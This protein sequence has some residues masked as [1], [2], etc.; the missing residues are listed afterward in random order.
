MRVI[1]GCE[2]S[3]AVRRA[4]RAL[5]HDAWS[6]DILPADDG[7]EH[8]YQCDIRDVPTGY[9]NHWDVGIFHPPC[10]RLT[11]SGVR[12]LHERNLWG[13][14][15]EAAELFR[16]CLAFPAKRKAVENP[17]PHRYALERI[18][19]KYD[20][21]IQPWQFGHGETKA[22][23]LWLDGLPPLEPTDVVDGR[24]AR[25]HRMSPSADRWKMRS[26]TYSGIAQAMAQQWGRGA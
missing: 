23:C 12:W 22:T 17:I 11:N 26:A 13:E 16:F 21:I 4:F 8:H 1:V 5:G 19:R 9:G 24:V 6:C 2:S 20:Q 10:T 18:G 15:D 25:V 7:C 3:G 14:L